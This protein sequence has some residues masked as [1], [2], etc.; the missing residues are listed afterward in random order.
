MREKIKTPFAK[1]I[2]EGNQENPYFS[3][4]YY[5]SDDKDFHIGY[6]SYR[7][8]YVFEWFRN[9]FDILEDEN[10]SLSFFQ[11][12]TREQVE[13]VWKSSWITVH[14]TRGEQWSKCCECQN[15][16]D[17]LEDGFLFCPLCGAPMTDEAVDMVMQ[18]LEALQDADD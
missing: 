16:L 2:V 5:S 12:I 14:S 18:R 11:P 9:E 7:L 17:G 13:K 10:F 3:I 4:L 1:I 15:E 6:G 8:D